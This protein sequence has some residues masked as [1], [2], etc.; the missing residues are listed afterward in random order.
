M[1]EI[2]GGRFGRMPSQLE[3]LLQVDCLP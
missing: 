2:W 3:V 1:F